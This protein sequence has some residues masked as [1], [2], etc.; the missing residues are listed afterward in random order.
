MSAPSPN[1]LRIERPQRPVDAIVDRV[2]RAV[3]DGEFRAGE[4]L[5]PERE[6]AVTLGVSRLTLRAALGRLET[7]GLVRARQGDGVRVLDLH[8]DATLAVLPYI[9]SSRRDELFRSFLELRRALACEAVALACERACDA[10]LDDLEARAERQRLESDDA[11]YIE[12]DLA[13]SRRVLLAADNLAMVLLFNTLV[14]VYKAHPELGRAITKDR[15]ASLAGYALVLGLLRNRDP[16]GARRSLAAMLAL[17][18][19]QALA[20]LPRP[21]P[22]KTS[23]KSTA[24]PGSRRP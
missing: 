20:H 24:K 5:P 4:T 6:L 8:E 23:T 14:P 22:P 13:F 12:G 15:E 10:D 16:E 11:R 2:R 7:E 21:R 9:E 3:L 18:D 17:A 19:A 1:S